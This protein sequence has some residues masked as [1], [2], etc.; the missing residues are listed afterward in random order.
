MK[1][2]RVRIMRDRDYE[3]L[4]FYRDQLKRELLNRPPTKEK[5]EELKKKIEKQEKKI[6]NRVKVCKS[7]FNGYYSLPK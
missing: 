2:T 7:A 4:H 5:V 6:A 1:T 3:I